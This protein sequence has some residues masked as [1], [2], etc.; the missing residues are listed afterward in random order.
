MKL[1]KK[2]YN[3]LRRRIVE[4]KNS[5]ER[6]MSE[7]DPKGTCAANHRGAI[8]ADEFVLELLDELYS[9]IKGKGS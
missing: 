3:Q 2:R 4:H 9:E 8:S 5:N 7:D 6:A 1:T